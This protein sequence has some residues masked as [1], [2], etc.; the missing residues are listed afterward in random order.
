MKVNVIFFYKSNWQNELL[1]LQRRN[2][3]IVRIYKSPLP[4]T[5][6]R[7]SLLIKHV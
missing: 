4:L 7:C 2:K 3:F 1:R 5:V 6:S